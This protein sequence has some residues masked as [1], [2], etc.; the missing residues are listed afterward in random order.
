MLPEKKPIKRSIYNFKKANWGDIKS[1]LSKVNWHHALNSNNIE[2][3][4]IKFKSKLT[5]VRNKHIPKIK[6]SNEFKPPWY[7]SEVFVI[8]RKKS[9][10]HTLYKKLAVTIT[11]L[12][13]L[14]ASEILLS[15]LL[16][17]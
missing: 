16:K 6:V 17:R 13:F 8:N 2:D 4:W 11:T 15:L 1:D 3:S 9:R 5:E 12:S 10:L 14:L 7:D